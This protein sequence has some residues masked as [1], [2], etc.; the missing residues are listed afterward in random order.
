MGS[1]SLRV[2]QG[3]SNVAYTEPIAVSHAQPVC[4]CS[5]VSIQTCVVNDIKCIGN[6]A[7]QQLKHNLRVA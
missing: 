3:L 6:V 7:Q 5:Q 4:K 2:V 1:D